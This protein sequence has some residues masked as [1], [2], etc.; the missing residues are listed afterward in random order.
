MQVFSKS[1]KMFSLFV[2]MEKQCFWVLPRK[3]HCTENHI[4]FFQTSWKDGVSKKPC[5]N[6]IFLALSG[7][8][9]FLLPENM[10]LH[11][12][13]KMKMIFLKKIL[14]NKTLSTNYL[15]RWSFQKGPRRDIIFL[16]LSGKMEFFFPKT[17]YF[18]FGQEVRVDL[19][20]E[21]HGNMIFSVYKYG[22]Y[23]RDVT[24]FYQKNSKMV[25]SRKNTPRGDWRSRLA[26]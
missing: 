1:D 8:I 21:M 23:K 22:C 2:A 18:L 6:K 17:W 7:K 12:R 26:F 15:K 10:I 20:Q 14:G 24:T 9:M 16:L 5:W 3:I 19:S 11:L 13:R 25:L 4:F